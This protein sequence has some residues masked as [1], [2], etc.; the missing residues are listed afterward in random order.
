ME[1]QYQQ[2]INDLPSLEI[3][4]YENIFKVFVTGDKKFY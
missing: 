1:G 2:Y 3:Y 4:R